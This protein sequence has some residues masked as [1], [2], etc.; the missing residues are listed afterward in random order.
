MDIKSISRSAAIMYAD[1]MSTKTT[2]TIKRKFVEAVFVNN[3]NQYFTINELLNRIE[4]ET[5][6]LF[7]ET[8]LK[9]I[10][11]NADYFVE[12]LKKPSE[13]TEYKLQE[14]RGH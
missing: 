3:S 1:S 8:E 11:C 14:K 5:G 9:P 12:F 10:V 6:L 7:S 4:D 2:N 13:L